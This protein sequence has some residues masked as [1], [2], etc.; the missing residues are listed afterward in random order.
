MRQCLK[1][2]IPFSSLDQK[3]VISLFL[4]LS[5]KEEQ[6]CC[7]FSA[8]GQRTL[9]LFLSFSPCNRKKHAYSPASLFLFRGMWISLFPLLLSRH[10][11]NTF[12]TYVLDKNE[13]TIIY[14]SFYIDP[15]ILWT[16]PLANI[17]NVILHFH[18]WSV[19]VIQFFPL[20]QSKSTHISPT[21]LWRELIIPFSKLFTLAVLT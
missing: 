20:V 7:I 1:C 11:Y 3:N 21:Q 16:S 10:K 18:L 9:N 2:Y 14:I 19:A 5:L 4:F 8:I 15:W 6:F 17:P 13:Q 12:S